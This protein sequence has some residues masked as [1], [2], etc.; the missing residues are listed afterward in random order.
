VLQLEARKL[1]KLV[2][3]TIDV[4]SSGSIDLIEYIEAARTHP[5]VLDMART[6]QTIWPD[7]CPALACQHEVSQTQ[8]TLTACSFPL[9]RVFRM[10]CKIALL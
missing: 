4:N 9:C 5:A 10:P 7:P 8:R 2:F 6:T 3:D 1:V